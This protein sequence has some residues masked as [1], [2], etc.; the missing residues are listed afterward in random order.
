MHCKVYR[1]DVINRFILERFTVDCNYLEIGVSDPRFCF[2]LI[3]SNEKTS[4]DPGIEFSENPVQFKMTSDSF[5]DLVNNG[6]T[7]FPRNHKWDIIF[8]DG[9]HIADQ[10][11]RDIRNALN[12]TKDNGVILIHD[13]NPPTWEHAHSI[14]EFYYNSGGKAWN[15]TVWK[16]FYLMRTLLDFSTY[17][18]DT[19]CG[20]GVI[21]KKYKSIPIKHENVFFDYGKMM[22][23]RKLHLGLISLEEFMLR[24]I[25]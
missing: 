17:T 5:F 21:D 2:D 24:K 25:S 23:D 15:G 8:I 9:L 11:F 1:Y 20:I 10:C 14:P 3:C 13:C 12:H 6:Q 22:N 7:K 16:S 18:I 4:V 19:D